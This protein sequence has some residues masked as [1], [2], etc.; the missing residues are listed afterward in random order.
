VISSFSPTV[1]SVGT[2]V[3]ITGINLSSPTELKI[4]GISAIIV[5]S[6]STKIV[7]LVMNGCKTGIITVMSSSGTANALDNFTVIKSSTYP[8]S[9]KVDKLVGTGEVGGTANQGYSISICADGNTAILD[10]YVDNNQLGEALVF[11]R[12][13]GIWLQQGS[14]VVAADA[15]GRIE[16]GRAVA[17][18]ADGNTAI[19]GEIMTT[20][21]RVLHGYLFVITEFGHSRA[22]N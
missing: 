1:G 7:G 20:I 21:I 12:S 5:S 15:V 4:G 16:Q 11:T 14:K 18:S 9:S 8:I 13:N 2:L 19:F 10:G 22:V 17:I 6:S 3:T